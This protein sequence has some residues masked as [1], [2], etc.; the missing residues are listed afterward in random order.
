MHEA[1]RGAGAVRELAED[2]IQGELDRQ[3]VAERIT[4]EDRDQTSAAEVAGHDAALP[5][6]THV[7]LACGLTEVQRLTGRL[8]RCDHLVSRYPPLDVAIRADLKPVGPPL[9]DDDLAAAL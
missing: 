7:V 8:E 4:A 5:T 9:D 1:E 6:A 3:V 2:V